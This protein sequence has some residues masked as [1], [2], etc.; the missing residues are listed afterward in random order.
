M[1]KAIKDLTEKEM[2]KV[3]KEAS[4]MKFDWTHHLEC[5]DIIG[6]FSKIKLSSPEDVKMAA[7]E[8]SIIGMSIDEG[9]DKL[10]GY[11][12][13]CIKMNKIDQANRCLPKIQRC[14]EFLNDAIHDA[15]LNVHSD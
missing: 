7:H 10:S 2:E 14:L 4:E 11:I 12:E 15:H 6:F 13:E 8:S 1:K 9:F 5:K 3:M